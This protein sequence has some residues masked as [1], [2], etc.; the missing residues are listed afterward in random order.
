MGLGLGL[1]GAGLAGGLL[2]AP[3]Q[4]VTFQAREA[5]EHAFGL[6]GLDG[7]F[8]AGVGHRA[9]GADGLGNA[10][11][12]ITHREEH[13]RVDAATGGVIEEVKGGGGN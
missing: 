4:P 6:T 3:H 5:A 10:G 7:E 8:E 2:P 11:V 1:G 9:R 12:V 13:S